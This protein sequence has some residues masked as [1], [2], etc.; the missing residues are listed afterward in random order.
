MRVPSCTPTTIHCSPRILYFGVREGEISKQ[1]KDSSA[2]TIITTTELFETAKAA[3]LAIKQQMPIIS[4]K[5]KDGESLPRGAINFEEMINT[6]TDIPDI[7]PG[8]TNDLAFMPYSSGTTGLPKGVEL[9]HSNLISVNA[10]ALHP[11]YQLFE[12]PTMQCL[13]CTENFHPSCLKQAK[14]SAICGHE[15][16]NPPTPAMGDDAQKN[17]EKDAEIA[18]LQQKEK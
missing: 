12:P 2:K 3:S 17:H 5:N 6:I 16:A 7:D 14:K 8:N 15:A 10:Q 18:K 9:T 13:K 1:L 11:D 4:M